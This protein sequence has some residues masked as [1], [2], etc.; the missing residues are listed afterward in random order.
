VEH[1]SEENENTPEARSLKVQ[2]ASPPQRKLEKSRSLKD[3]D[4]SA[5]YK[6]FKVK[7]GRTESVENR[8]RK[9]RPVLPSILNVPRRKKVESA[10]I[11]TYDP[12]RGEDIPPGGFPVQRR[13][14]VASSPSH[15]SQS[16][17]KKDFSIDS[18]QE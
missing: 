10:R 2:L 13:K 5:E 15:T 3:I 1:K 9:E 16:Q 17:S 7:F 8:D 6:T 14:S 11:Q 12:I 4:A 18:D